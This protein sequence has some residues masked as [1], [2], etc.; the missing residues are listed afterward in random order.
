[1]AVRKMRYIPFG[2]RLVDG[3]ITVHEREAG[4]VKIIFTEY[5][6][7]GRSYKDIAA[8]LTDQGVAYRENVLNWNKSMIKRILSRQKREIH[9]ERRADHPLH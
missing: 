4:A 7:N 1:M 3:E 6:H 8:M 5:L 9:P 2:Y